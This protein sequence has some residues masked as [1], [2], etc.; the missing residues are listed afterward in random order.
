LDKRYLIHR[1]S[2]AA[3][4]WRPAFAPARSVRRSTCTS[5]GH[6]TVLKISGRMTTTHCADQNG[7]QGLFPTQDSQQAPV[8]GAGSKQAG[9][10]DTQIPTQERAST[11]AGASS[12]F[13]TNVRL[14]GR[15][16]IY[17]TTTTVAD[18]LPKKIFFRTRPDVFVLNSRLQGSHSNSSGV[19]VVLVNSR[20]IPSASVG[21]SCSLA[22]TS[23]PVWSRARI[24]PATYLNCSHCDCRHALSRPSPCPKRS[25]LKRGCPYRTARLPVVW[26]AG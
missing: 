6:L 19:M 9:A 24:A 17:A 5:I 20:R 10:A 23:S 11:A 21:A 4:R 12:P 13:S 26:V 14:A 18:P 3:T 15:T 7:R 1:R 25:P 2:M 22:Q 16:W 8:V